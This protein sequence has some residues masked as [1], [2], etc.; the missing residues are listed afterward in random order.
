MSEVSTSKTDAPSS[1][2]KTTAPLEGAA[3]RDAIQ[4]QIEYY[5]SKEN[6]QGDS[7]LVSHMDPQLFVPVNIIAGFKQLKALTADSELL[8][9]VIRTSEKVTLDES[10]TKI[11]PNFQHKR[12]TLIL[13]DIPKETPVEEVAALFKGEGCPKVE[14]SMIRPDVLNTWFVTFEEEDVTLQAL[15][16]LRTQKFGGKPVRCAVKSE[17]ILKSL[18]FQPA[19]VPVYPMDPTQYYPQGRWD[20]G[21]QGRQKRK[22]KK[23]DG[24]QQQ[25]PTAM[26][27][28]QPG[29]SSANL[30]PAHFPPLPSK[31][32]ESAGYGKEFT[33]YTKERI[34]EIIKATTATKLEAMD[35]SCVV[36]LQRPDTSLEAD[37]DDHDRRSSI[38]FEPPNPKE[39]MRVPLPETVKEVAS[40]PP[41]PASPSKESKE[42]VPS[43]QVSYAAMASKAAG[44]SPSK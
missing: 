10:G 41:T 2:E 27:P 29:Q 14:E 38:N 9:D 6:L 37:K 11:R 12:N 44:G 23:R 26:P 34:V 8:L 36:V 19:T 32:Q 31:G 21:N 17:N 15:N 1:P 28:A 43:S 18:Y 42:N 24:Q 25:I 40:P 33:R 20:Y 30:N 5:F 39:I 13:R 7:Y 22:G 3:L 4:K 35:T 16:F